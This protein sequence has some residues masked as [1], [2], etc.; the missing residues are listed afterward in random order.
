MATSTAR[1]S[2][3]EVIRAEPF[4]PHPQRVL[5]EPHR[6]DVPAAQV[7]SPYLVDDEA[8]QG[9]IGRVEE[10]ALGLQMLQ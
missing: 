8:P 7:Q 10:V 1:V 4:P 9:R 3:C 6:L 5:A 2:T